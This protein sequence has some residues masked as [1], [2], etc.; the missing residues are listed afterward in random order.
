MWAFTSSKTFLKAACLIAP[1]MGSVLVYVIAGSIIYA[2][3]ALI[4][5]TVL[6]WTMI[7]YVLIEPN[8][9][10]SAKLLTV[11]S[12]VATG[13]FAATA[14]AT[15]KSAAI[16]HLINRGL[17]LFFPDFN[18]PAPTA[19][20]W[21]NALVAIAIVVATILI[22]WLILRSDIPEDGSTRKPTAINPRQL[23]VI[24]R[25][26]TDHI[27]KL[28]QELRFFDFRTIAIDPKLEEL[29]STS[30]YVRIRSA[31]EVVSAAQDGHFIVVKGEPGSG[32]SVMLR[33][34]ARHLLQRVEAK[35]K[36]PILLNLK[37]WPTPDDLSHLA[38]VA[39]LDE[40][41]KG[42]FR[43]RTG[44]RAAAISDEEFSQ[45]FAE[46]SLIFLFD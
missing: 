40:W 41:A 22:V 27:D 24:C 19:I 46:G 42:E 30:R 7:R 29:N 35:G 8:N 28:D 23:A 3:G 44:G 45:L 36:I 10:K 37:E 25:T 17:R 32:K 38:L 43:T 5:T 20:N 31:A 13:L 26:L 34:L 2:M 1:W 14:V 16:W 21:V 18:P 4:C 15:S 33:N 6:S 39:S 9:V 11:S 12:V